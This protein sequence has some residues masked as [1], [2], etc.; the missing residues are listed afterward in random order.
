MPEFSSTDLG[1]VRW[2][3]IQPDFR[4][5]PEAWP[6]SCPSPLPSGGWAVVV[7]EPER[8][9]PRRTVVSWAQREAALTLT[10]ET[11]ACS[12]HM[13]SESHLV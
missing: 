6:L 9:L 13:A 7:L 1:G 3:Y 8:E 4:L 12:K 11:K 10:L 5:Y 2:Q